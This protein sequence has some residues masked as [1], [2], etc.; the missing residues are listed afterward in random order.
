MV[1]AIHAHD[2]EPID[3]ECTC[4]TCRHF[5]KAY[6]RHLINAKEILSSTLL[7]IHN[8]HTLLQFARE[9]REAIISGSFEQLASTYLKNNP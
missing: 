5:S 6:L 7:S 9:I 4:Y 2:P 3:I 8:L 1:N